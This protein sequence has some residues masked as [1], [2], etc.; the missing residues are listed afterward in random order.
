[1]AQIIV[2]VGNILVIQVNIAIRI[3][4]SSL[5][6][7]AVWCCQE[8][9]CMLMEKFCLKL[10][11][12]IKYVYF[13]RNKLF[14]GETTDGTFKVKPNNLI[15]AEYLSLL[16]NSSLFRLYLNNDGSKSS[17]LTIERIKL[18]TWAR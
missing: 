17:M 10:I 6:D 13:V 16:M 12:T 7:V 8:P 15:V 4:P 9:D 11:Y 2:L 14:H 3:L 1:M 18:D 5:P